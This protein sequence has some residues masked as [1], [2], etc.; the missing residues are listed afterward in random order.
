M[1]VEGKGFSLKRAL[2]ALVTAKLENV[3]H[4]AAA[5][6]A[7]GH[8]DREAL[9]FCRDCTRDNVD[10][11]LKS[12]VDRDGRVLRRIADE[13]RGGPAFQGRAAAPQEGESVDELPE[14]LD[15]IA[16][17]EGMSYRIRNLYLLNLDLC[18]KLAPRMV[19]SVNGEDQQ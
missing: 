9:A 4:A 5:F 16:W 8:D 3:R 12:L 1:N 13:V 7:R 15:G 19:P 10:E 2:P 14:A 17:P 11:V 6:I 18:G